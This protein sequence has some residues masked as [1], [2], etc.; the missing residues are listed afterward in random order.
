MYARAQP[1][2]APT[3]L[4]RSPRSGKITAMAAG[5]RKITYDSAQTHTQT[6]LKH[7]S[8]H[9][10]THTRTVVSTCNEHYTCSEDELECGEDAL[11]VVR[12]VML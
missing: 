4:M 9:T 2:T 5:K 7:Q 8:I 12:V 3:R 6:C 1:E 10:R 11:S